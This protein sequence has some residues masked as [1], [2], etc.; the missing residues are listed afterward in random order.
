MPTKTAEQ[1][2]A[3]VPM[4]LAEVSSSGS[5]APPCGGATDWSAGGEPPGD[6]IVWGEVRVRS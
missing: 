3:D 5:G 1:V 2:A 6:V 4:M